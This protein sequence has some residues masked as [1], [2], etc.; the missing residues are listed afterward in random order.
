M[1]IHFSQ[2]IT[3]IYLPSLFVR[4]RVRIVAATNRDLKKEIAAG[5]FREDLYYRLNVFPIEIAPLRERKEDIP[6]LASHFIDTVVNELSCPRPRL[7]RA[8]TEM[9][10]NYDWPGNIRELCN[11][12]QRAAILAQGGALEFDLPMGNPPAE[13][14]FQKPAIR[15]DSNAGYLTEAEIRRREREN[16]SIVLQKTGWRI[17]GIGGAAELL[18]VS[19]TTLFA[20]IE[21]MGF[22]RPP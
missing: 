17:K 1:A 7:T 14:T 12:I 21:K 20:R 15:D 5:R 6:G 8:G 16:L 10:L 18:G 11:V 19:P 22:R 2:F 3:E 4:R 13:L 9:L